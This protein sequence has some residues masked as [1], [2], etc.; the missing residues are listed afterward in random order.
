MTEKRKLKNNMHLNSM[1]NYTKIKQSPKLQ[2]YIQKDF[3]LLMPKI[4]IFHNQ[5]LNRILLY[6][7]A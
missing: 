1:Y 6:E 4:A 3:N 5:F 2:K 7:N